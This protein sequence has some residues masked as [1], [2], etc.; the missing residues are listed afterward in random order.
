MSSTDVED[1]ID[2]FGKEDSF[3]MGIG[4]FACTEG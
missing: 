3:G 2:D 1:K 4:T